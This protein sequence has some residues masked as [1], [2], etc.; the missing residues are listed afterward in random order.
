[1][2]NTYHILNGDALLEQFPTSILGKRIVARACLVDGPVKSTSLQQLYATRAAFISQ[3]YPGFSIADYYKHGVSQF[4]QIQNIPS[5]STVCLWFEDD[6]FCQVNC[7]FALH[8]LLH[9]GNSHS[10]F[11]VRPPKLTPYGFGGL[12]T[13]DLE[14]QYDNKHQL[15]NYEQWKQLWPSYQ[16]ESLKELIQI[17]KELNSE[18]PF[19]QAAIQAHLDRIPTANSIGKPKELLLEIIQELTKKEFGP[20]FKAFCNRAPIYGFGDLQVRRMF[21]EL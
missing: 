9:S 4:S 13:S 5:G 12:S 2:P 21:D 10:I 18:Y 1:M 7:W 16:T 11:L 15:T 14:A 3:S 6:L 17:G 20:V 19:V 8:L